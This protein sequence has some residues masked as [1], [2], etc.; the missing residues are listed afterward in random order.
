MKSD[1]AF[2]QSEYHRILKTG[3]DLAGGL[4]DLA[5]RAS[6]YFHLYED[7]GG[8]NVFPLIAAHGALWASAYFARGMRAGWILSAQY[9]FRPGLRA[10]RY[11]S[12]ERF[13]DAFRDINRRVCAESYCAYHFT[14]CYGDTAL[15]AALIPEPLLESLN[16]CHESRRQDS[17]FL[18]DQRRALFEAFFRW[19]QTHIVAPAVDAAVQDFD[20]PAVKWLAMRPKIE[21]AYLGRAN[22]LQF[23]NFADREERIE[24]GLRAYELAEMAGLAQVEDS[25]RDYRIMPGHFFE[26]SS[27]FFLALKNAMPQ[28]S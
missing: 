18:S 9:L 13:A 21:F 11:R 16:R 7:S 19:E 22:S 12:L 1:D 10:A 6:V 24:R 14:K 15:A 4:T 20:W 25:I 23:R 5:Q 27:G 8:R 28:Q 26:D 3:Y 17:P 2:L